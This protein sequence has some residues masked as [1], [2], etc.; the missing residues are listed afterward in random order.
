MRLIRLALFQCALLLLNSTH[1]QAL[2]SHQITQKI[3][4]IVAVVN[5]EVITLNEL[6]L[7][8]APITRRLQRQNLPSQA[9]YHLRLQVLNQMVLECIQLQRAKDSGIVINDTLLQHTL[10]RLARVNN[11]SLDMY[12][13]RLESE[14]ISWSKFLADVQNKLLLL[15][16]REKE[17]DS[18]ITV[19][20]TEVSDYIASQNG[21]QRREQDLCFEHILI[22]IQ[23][24]ALPTKIQDA[25][26]KALTI[27]KRALSKEDFIQLATAN[28]QAPD[29]LK[30]G[31]SGFC[32][33]SL[34]PKEITQ[35]AV[36]L[37]PGQ[38]NPKILR[39]VE[40]FEI[41]RLI[42]R[43]VSSAS[44]RKALRFVQKHARHI[45]IRV[46]EE[47]SELIAQKKL[48]ELRSQIEAG[49]DFEN[50]ARTYSED[51]SAPMGGDL[52]W[53]NPGETIPEFERAMNNLENNKISQPVRSDYGY[54]LIQV[55]GR[56]EARDSISKQQKIVR[57]A[58]GQYKARKAY[59]DWLWKLHDI[60]YIQYK[61][62]ESI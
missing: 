14:G 6:E 53:L 54:H 44:H 34:L 45:L 33:E 28:S 55:I 50:F 10:V 43:R 36:R 39:T 29:A 32:P 42:D 58:I 47:R 13:S 9:L 19:S 5:N 15:K 21:M 4:R 27:L 38:I 2:Q 23:P 62:D 24:N 48:L 25:Q 8:M 17:V 61:L 37:R 30:G 26:K 35:A 3:D 52:G 7:R 51:S 49:G 60:S 18:K 16:L 57:Q 46:S 56:R 12:R 41:L 59:L 22:K 40:G 11:M 1:A 31:N 20:D